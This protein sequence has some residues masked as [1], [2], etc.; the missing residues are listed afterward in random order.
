[1]TIEP[2]AVVRSKRRTVDDH[3][4][5]SVEATI[6]LRDDVPAESLSGLAEFSH[7]EIV[8][9]F[10]QLDAS[11]VVRGSRHP[12]K[13]RSRSESHPA[14]FAYP[15]AASH[16]PDRKRRAFSWNFPKCSS[17]EQGAARPLRINPV[18]PA[19]LL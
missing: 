12:R 5:G 14:V 2:V 10:D 8:F 15:A 16:R 18:P 7:A 17:E 4:W 13:W 9:V 19:V 1:M 3:H 6:E 11:V